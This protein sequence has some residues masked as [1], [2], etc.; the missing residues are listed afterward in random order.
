MDNH[1]QQQF[2]RMQ[3]LDEYH[4]NGKLEDM[5]LSNELL[6]CFGMESY[7]TTAPGGLPSPNSSNT[8]LPGSGRQSPLLRSMS[9]FTSEYD[10]HQSDGSSDV[11]NDFLGS[12][13]IQQLQESCTGS[14]LNTSVDHSNKNQ[15]L[16]DTSS[17]SLKTDLLQGEPSMTSSNDT[18]VGPCQSFIASSDGSLCASF[19]N[20]ASTVPSEGS[21]E[22]I[23]LKSRPASTH[24]PIAPK[25]VNNTLSTSAPANI[26]HSPI[27][28]PQHFARHPSHLRHQ[29]HPEQTKYSPL[30][31]TVTENNITGPLPHTM[32]S[33]SNSTNHRGSNALPSYGNYQNVH[34]AS[35]RPQFRRTTNVH[36]QNRGSPVLQNYQPFQESSLRSSVTL[37]S[38][39]FLWGTGQFQTPQYPDPQP[40]FQQQSNRSP[41]I[42]Q[43]HIPESQDNCM[44][45][46]SSEQYFMQPSDSR[47]ASFMSPG[48]TEFGFNG[49]SP[50][51][52]K[53]ELSS[54][55]LDLLVPT[56]IL[57][58]QLASPK[59]QKKRRV[60]QE[61][62]N[63]DDS[64]AAIDPVAL[65]T[66]DLTNLDPTDHTNLAALIDA[67]HNTDNAE[68]NQGMQK[69][70]EKARRAKAMRI[71]EV[72]AELLVSG[73]ALQCALEGNN[74]NLIPR[75]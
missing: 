66:A 17:G 63:N 5:P 26:Q 62:K 75:T 30:T 32:L 50:L 37:N 54:P 58:S 25:I 3:S 70:W 7:Q 24:V 15:N 12:C 59:S 71:R 35:S 45:S 72:C 31:G 57:R 65:Q 20:P 23:A 49:S 36:N 16:S 11:H 56:P 38:G 51:S 1:F 13:L 64:E 19:Q 52:V 27:S 21:V 74:N 2:Q 41:Y 67:M 60:K 69:T 48:S 34:H 42:G 47:S 10:S 33:G 4:Q 14:G 55:D 43:H 18:N 22:H 61:S 73:K 8:D 6:D 29:I 53:R 28:R 44:N 9:P 68:D 39:Q 46:Y 40:I